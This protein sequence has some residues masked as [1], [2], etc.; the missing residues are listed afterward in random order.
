MAR[1][2]GHGRAAPRP[3][4]APADLKLLDL[5]FALLEAILLLLPLKMR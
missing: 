2:R 1:S 3:S 5:P 4:A